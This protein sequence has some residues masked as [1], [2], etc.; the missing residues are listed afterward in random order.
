MPLILALSSPV[1]RGSLVLRNGDYH[2]FRADRALKRA[3]LHV[4]CRPTPDALER[5]HRL[6]GS[7]GFS[8]LVL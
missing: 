3:G 4:K 6:V 2:M 1:E 8:G 7:G 5:T